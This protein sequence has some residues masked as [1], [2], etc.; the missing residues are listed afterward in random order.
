MLGPLFRC[1]SCN[2]VR[3]CSGKALRRVFGVKTWVCGGCRIN[4]DGDGHPPKPKPRKFVGVDGKLTCQPKGAQKVF[5][6]GHVKPSNCGH[7]FPMYDPRYSLDP[8]TFKGG[9][10]T[11][12][13]VGRYL[14]EVR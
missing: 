2:K 1:A 5:T 8:Q 4:I 11:R 7:N 13:G 6:K 3:T 14:E 10:F 12:L 9:E